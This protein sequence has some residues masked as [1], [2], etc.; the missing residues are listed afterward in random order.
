MVEHDAVAT[1]IRRRDEGRL[2]E[3]TAGLRDHLV[4]HETDARAWAALANGQLLLRQEEAAWE[5]ISQALALAPD[6]DWVQRNLARVLTRRSALEAAAAAACRALAVDGANRE[7]RHV[8]CAVRAVSGEIGAALADV[9]QLLEDHPDFADA[10]ALRAVLLLQHARPAEAR[11][12]AGAAIRLGYLHPEAWR[13]LQGVGDGAGAIAALRRWLQVQPEDAAAMTALGEA[14]R[15][16]GQVEA[17]LD[18]FS[19]AV[20]ED[21]GAAAAW[22]G[23]GAALQ[24]ML[25][26][27]E[28]V[29]AYEM[30]LTLDPGLTGVSVNLAALYERRGDPEAA[31]QLLREVCESGPTAPDTHVALGRNLLLLDRYDQAAAE[32]RRALALDPGNL[33]ALKAVGDVDGAIRRCG[34]IAGEGQLSLTLLED[35]LQLM[36]SEPGAVG[37]M[38]TWSRYAGMVRA[39]PREQARLA[40]LAVIAAWMSGDDAAVGSLLQAHAPAAGAVVERRDRNAFRFLQYI[41]RL[42]RFR[43]VRPDLYQGP[44]SRTVQ[45]VGDSH[46]LALSGLTAGWLGEPAAFRSGLVMGVQMRHLASPGPNRAQRHFAHHLRQAPAGADLLLTVGEIDC[47]PDEGIWKEWRRKG[48]ALADIATRVIDGHFAWLDGLQMDR[49]RAVAIQGIPAPA[50]KLKLETGEREADHFD[51]VRLVNESM[52]AHTRARGWLFLDVHQATVGPDGRASGEWR[53][54]DYHLSPDFYAQPRL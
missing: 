29:A 39:G 11:A 28:A 36:I 40:S 30:A 26:D 6:D 32:F 38:E 18:W 48:G 20:D 10:H 14:L 52:A 3:M 22:H 35:W 7:N 31:V 47:R 53:I 17:A 9:D 25:R 1:A 2:R 33:S 34:A 21:G 27:E 45:G 13:L 37:V 50:Y 12:A 24:E 49:F 43:Q 5:A 54:D 15:A 41:A 16:S 44:A 4:S 42:H 23:Y 19:R 46:A 51:L 8:A